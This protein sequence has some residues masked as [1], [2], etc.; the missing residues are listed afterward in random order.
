MSTI[1]K[2]SINVTRY[3][4]LRDSADGTPET[5]YT[6][7]NLD[8][9][10]TRN[11]TAPA[12][13]ADATALAATDSVYG[14]NKAIQIDATSS[15][16]LYRVDWPDGAFATGVDKVILVV[17]G[18]GL[19]P[20]VE[21]IELVD[22]DPEDAVRL[23]LT[24]LPNAAADAAGGLPISD[25]GGLD[26]D[27]I[28]GSDR[29]LMIDTTIDTLSSQTSFTLASGSTDDDAY[30]NCTIVVED[31]STSTQKAVGL[32]SDYTGSTKAV[33][34][35]YDPAVF[36]M[37]DTDKVYILAENSLKSSAAN[38]PLD[39]TPNGTAGIDWN[40]IETPNAVNDLSATDIQLCGTV[41]TN[42]DTA[43]LLPAALVGGRM[44][45]NSSAIGGDATAATNLAASALGIVPGVVEGSPTTTSIPSDLTEST[46]DHYIGR[47]V[48][49]TSG[50]AAGQASDITDYATD[51]ELTVTA[52]TTA[53]AAAD[54]FVIV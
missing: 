29:L 41:T 35:K 4:M 5:G 13:K 8:L 2:G 15:P 27:A 12:A 53:P 44:D 49:F 19:D 18:T 1:L 14:A 10:Y 32:V 47:I 7:T 11:R 16:G 37:A 21:E 6:I 22:Y 9:Q 52:L 31:V 42:T 43:A 48:V 40:N 50:V 51:G 20:A 54:T 25:A 30:N 39:V 24:A 46:A 36:V 17:S 28:G 33:T 34:L 38:R 45:S 3:I 26:M 23:G